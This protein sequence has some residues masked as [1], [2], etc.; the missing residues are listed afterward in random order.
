MQNCEPVQNAKGEWYCTNCGW[1]PE[2]KRFIKL[3]HTPQPSPTLP[4]K[5]ASKPE[6]TE[7]MLD[8]RFELG[9]A[10][11]SHAEAKQRLTICRNHCPAHLSDEIHPGVDGCKKCKVCTGL[12]GILF[13][14]RLT[15]E[16]PP[17]DGCLWAKQTTET[18]VPPGGSGTDS[19]APGAIN[20][21]S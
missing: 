12:R 17:V 15:G 3:C 5:E 19:R 9:L 7:E 2:R 1:G 11:L 18:V 4:Q 21:T 13:T 16:V 6:T 10:K 8:A 20:T 14:K